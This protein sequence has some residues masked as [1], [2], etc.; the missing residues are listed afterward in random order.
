MNIL[1][2]FLLFVGETSCFMWFSVR[3]LFCFFL[4]LINWKFSWSDYYECESV[5]DIHENQTRTCQVG[6]SQINYGSS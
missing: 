1:I 2:Y 4:N 5:E 3:K 6:F